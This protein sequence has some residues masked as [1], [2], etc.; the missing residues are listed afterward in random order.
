MLWYGIR[1]TNQ[2]KEA[3][4]GGTGVIGGQGLLWGEAC[5]SPGP[6]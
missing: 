3:K 2:R 1:V 6:V 5:L 4:R